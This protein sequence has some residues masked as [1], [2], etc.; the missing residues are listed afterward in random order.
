MHRQINCKLFL[1]FFIAN[2]Y[3]LQTVHLII[4]ISE[5]P[6]NSGK[7]EDFLIHLYLQKNRQTSYEICRFMVRVTGVEPA[8]S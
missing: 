4:K 2:K 3:I 7:T 8:A 6:K 1:A 5:V